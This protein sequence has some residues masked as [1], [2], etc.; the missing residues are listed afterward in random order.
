MPIKI[1]TVHTI[2]KELEQMPKELIV[3]HCL[4]M[5]KYKKDNKELLNYLLFEAD[6]ELDYINTIKEEI[7]TEFLSIDKNTFYYTKKNIRR[8]LRVVTKHI[9]HSGKKET[10]IELL[11]CFCLNMQNCGVSFKESKV[12]VNLYERQ[13]KNINKALNTLHEDIRIDFEDDIDNINEGLK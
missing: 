13:V 11:I 8:I 3:E 6:N 2:K 5:A 1:N 12:M 7:E 9:K 10:A 4:R